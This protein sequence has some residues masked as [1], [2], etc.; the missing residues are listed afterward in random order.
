[1]LGLGL[2]HGSRRQ[3]Q[4]FVAGKHPAARDYFAIGHRRPMFEAFSAWI[5]IGVECLSDRSRELFAR[6]CSWRFWARTP[7]RGELSCGV[8][9]NSSDSAGRPFP[10]LVM[11][12]G[13]LAAWEE[14]WDLLPCACEGVWGQMEELSVRPCSTLDQ[15][16][17]GVEL[18]RPP[19]AD[20][21]GLLGVRQQVMSGLEGQVQAASMWVTDSVNDAAQLTDHRMPQGFAACPPRPV[22]GYRVPQMQGGGHADVLPVLQVPANTADA[23]PCDRLPVQLFIP[24]VAKDIRELFPMICLLHLQLKQKIHA[25]PNSLFIGGPLD[26]AS[27]ALFNRA[28][29]SDD[30]RRMWLSDSEG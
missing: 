20:W 26:H 15:V 7:E 24:L 12:I 27:I 17:D 14:N 22:S 13:R 11:G 4:W 28:L 5:R 1:M 30:F 3:W 18:L 9:R 29:N 6:P 2:R 16:R 25:V 23:V 10:L 21:H 19:E 8:V